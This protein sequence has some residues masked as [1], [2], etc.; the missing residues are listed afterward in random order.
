MDNRRAIL[1]GSCIEAAATLVAAGK[2]GDEK[3]PDYPADAVAKVTRMLTDELLHDAMVA[4]AEF[5]PLEG[6]KFNFHEIIGFKVTDLN[7]GQVGTIKGVND[8]TAQA[9]FIIDHEG[10]EILIPINDEFIVKLDRENSTITLNTP[11][12]LIDLYL[13]Q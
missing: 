12:G 8:Q 13:E 11:E 6:N 9:L 10:T 4:S 3:S 2:V 1:I 7:K 5:P